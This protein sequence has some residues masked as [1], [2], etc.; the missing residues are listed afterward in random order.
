MGIEHWK[1]LV[2]YEVIYFKISDSIIYD[3]DSERFKI[4]FGENFSRIGEHKYI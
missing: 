3:D 4:L 2:G 1:N